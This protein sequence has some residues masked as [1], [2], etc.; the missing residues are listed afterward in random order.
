MYLVKLE[1]FLPIPSPTQLPTP[2][3]TPTPKPFSFDSLVE[4][5]AI[6]IFVI[7]FLAVIIISLIY[8]GH[9]KTANVKQ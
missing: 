2:I 1:P 6:P 4:Q 9:R 3:P 5:L 8:R 7:A